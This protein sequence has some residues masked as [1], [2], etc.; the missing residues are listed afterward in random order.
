MARQL[1]NSEEGSGGV[2][3]ES[4]EEVMQVADFGSN[5][6]LTDELESQSE[7]SESTTSTLD[8]VAIARPEVRS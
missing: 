6:A 7:S 5:A 4:Q 2:S 8:L 1:K 3:P